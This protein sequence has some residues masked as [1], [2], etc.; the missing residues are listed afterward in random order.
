MLVVSLNNSAPDEKISVSTVTNSLLNEEVKRWSLET[1]Q[2]EDLVTENQRRLKNKKK[3]QGHKSRS[4]S[5][6][7]NDDCFNCGK[8]GHYVK[9]CKAQKSGLRRKRN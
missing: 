9:Q 6:L 3:S 8:K 1:S 4:Q 7:K 5:R 2:T